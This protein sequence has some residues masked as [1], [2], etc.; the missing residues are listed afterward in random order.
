MPVYEYSCK[1][2]TTFERLLRMDRMREPLAH[3]CPKCGEKGVEQ[4]PTAAGFIDPIRLGRKRPNSGFTEAMARVKEQHPLGNFDMS[5][6][7]TGIF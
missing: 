7:T 6:G 2:G 5:I 3:P 1:C 4:K